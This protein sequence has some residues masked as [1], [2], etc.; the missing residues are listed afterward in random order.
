MVINQGKLQGKK[1]K[2]N[3]KEKFDKI[4]NLI[5]RNIKTVLTYNRIRTLLISIII[6]TI[7][8]TLFTTI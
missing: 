7:T 6:N 1:R 8:K 3:R 5:D 2:K 4:W